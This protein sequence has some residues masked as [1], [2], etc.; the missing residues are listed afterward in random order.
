MRRQMAVSAASRMAETVGSSAPSGLSRA[1]SRAWAAV[2]TAADGVEDEVSPQ[3]LDP[4]ALITAGLADDKAARLGAGF[5]RR[6]V[7]KGRS[8][9]RTVIAPGTTTSR[10]TTTRD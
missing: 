9:S 1:T 7:A 6:K 8:R 3:A 2:V 10:G 4:A 5:S